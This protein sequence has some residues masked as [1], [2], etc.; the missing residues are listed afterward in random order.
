MCHK[1]VLNLY[2]AYHGMSDVLKYPKHMRKLAFTGIILQPSVASFM[3]VF[4]GSCAVLLSSIVTLGGSNEHLFQLL[5][6]SDSSGE[7]ID[8]TKSIL[9]GVGRTIFG[10][11]ILNTILFFS[12]WFLVGLVAYVIVSGAGSG[13]GAV[14]KFQD[15]GKMLHVHKQML[16][17]ETFLRV[18]LR[19]TAFFGW[20]LYSILFWKLLLP[21]SVLAFQVASSGSLQISTLLTGLLGFSVLLVSLHLHVVLLRCL[22]LR[23][24]VVGGWDD[25]IAA[26]LT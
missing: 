21:F 3:G 22:L 17:K 12:F 14:Q 10:N 5:L 24:R 18:V 11:S 4:L 2:K 26:H 16:E 6:G 23:P 25:V 7:L 20:A 1:N 15:K 19:A 9:D 13:I 8:T